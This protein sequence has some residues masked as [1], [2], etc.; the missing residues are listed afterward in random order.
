MLDDTLYQERILD[1]YEQPFHRGS[2]PFAT[3]CHEATNPL[4][5]DRIRIELRVN[6]EGR[7]ED[8]YFQGDGC[9]VSLSAAS[10]LVEHCQGKALDAVRSLQPADMLSLFA[11][12][13]TITRQKCCLLGWRVL[14]AAIV[15]PHIPTTSPT[16]SHGFTQ[17]E[18]QR[19]I[20]D[21]RRQS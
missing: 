21:K 5:G 10:M 11:A 7:I 16:S 12:P 15:C 1:Y 18:S 20:A 8:A 4:C 9:C 3:H 14:Q 2:C 13:L 6:P 19:S 17:T